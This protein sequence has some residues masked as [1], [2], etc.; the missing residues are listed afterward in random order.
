MNCTIKFS[1]NKGFEEY[2]SD[3]QAKK[4]AAVI[5]EYVNP[6]E[7]NSSPETAPSKRIL[8]IDRGYNKVLQGNLIAL[9]V[10]IDD[11]LAKCPRFSFWISRLLEL[12][13]G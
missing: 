1:N 11:M 6:E 7:I 12:S 4:T 9:N 3:E 10:G 2:L 13:K 8:S 5:S